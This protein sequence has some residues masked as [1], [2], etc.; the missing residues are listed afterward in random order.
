MLIY[1]IKIVCLLF[2][3]NISKVRS[4][5]INVICSNVFYDDPEDCPV[6]S[7]IVCK[8]VDSN[9]GLDYPQNFTQAVS[10]CP[11]G[12]SFKNSCDYR[13]SLNSGSQSQSILSNN[14]LK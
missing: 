2:L 6:S 7:S 8:W 5:S 11:T 3:I 9:T 14:C 4:F 10:S 1:F 13:C 12:Y